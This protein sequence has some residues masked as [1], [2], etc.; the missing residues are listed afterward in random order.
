MSPVERTVAQAPKLPHFD[1]STVRN[2]TLSVLLVRR[3][4]GH[5][6]ADRLRARLLLEQRRAILPHRLF[7]NVIDARQPS[8][9]DLQHLKQFVDQHVAG[10]VGK[11]VPPTHASNDSN[12]Q[13]SAS[14]AVCNVSLLTRQEVQACA[15]VDQ[16]LEHG[17]YRRCTFLLEDVS[18][19]KLT[20]AQL[21]RFD[22]IFVCCPSKTV[23]FSL[24]DRLGGPGGNFAA[25]CALL[26]QHVP[27][28]NSG[29]LVIDQRAN[30]QCTARRFFAA[31]VLPLCDAEWCSDAALGASTGAS[32]TS[33]TAAVHATA[34]TT[35][36]NGGATMTMPVTLQGALAL[37]AE[38]EA[39]GA[40]AFSQCLLL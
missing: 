19:D 7:E 38:R 29:A 18:L 34:S 23:H 36:M 14:L 25:F 35:S 17:H 30:E 12:N 10:V 9:D 6:Y 24:F 4:S 39:A 20:D 40:S 31:Q 26:K 33:S 15:T 27:P 21:R 11:D 16:L 3:T 28:H 8:T 2:N 37:L 1:W 32:P 5:R 13:R 22:L